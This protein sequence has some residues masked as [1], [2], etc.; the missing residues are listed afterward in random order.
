MG[1]KL[2]VE[3]FLDFQT[4]EFYRSRGR[5]RCA[6]VLPLIYDIG[7]DASGNG[8]GTKEIPLL[9]IWTENNSKDGSYVAVMLIQAVQYV[10]K[11]AA[12]GS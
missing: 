2:L 10:S 8:K 12:M 11:T 4:E 7:E 1:K 6:T 3:H 9:N 5:R